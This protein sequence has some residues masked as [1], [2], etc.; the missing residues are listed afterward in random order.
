MNWKITLLASLLACSGL[1]GAAQQQTLKIGTN[2]GYAPFEIKNSDGTL[3]GLDIDI[4]NELCKRLSARCIWVDTAFDGL[5]P[6]LQANKI[7]LINSSMNI[8]E[9]RQQSIAFTKP[10]YVVPIQMV[11]RKDAGLQPTAQ[12]LKGKSVGVLQGSSQADFALQ[13]WAKSGVNVVAYPEQD[14]IF[15]DLYVGRLDAALQETQSAQDAFLNQPQGRDFGFAGDPVTDPVTLGQGTGIGMR[16]K[17]DALLLQVNQALDGMKADGTL[18][19]L[20]KRY[21]ARDITAR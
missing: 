18:E 8:T 7:D 9:K 13:H 2:S 21:F 10:I 5:I 14:Q 6:S 19:T 11:A 4:G 1:V 20:S 17:D 15:M 12:S 16:K 3:A